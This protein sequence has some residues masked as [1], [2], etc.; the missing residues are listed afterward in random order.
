[1]HWAG[2]REIAENLSR[3]SAAGWPAVKFYAVRIGRMTGR[4]FDPNAGCPLIF[5]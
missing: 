2:F 3:G 1:M 4:D 5:Q